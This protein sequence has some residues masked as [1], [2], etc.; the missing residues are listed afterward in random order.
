MNKNRNVA[1]E[2]LFYSSSALSNQVRFD[3]WRERKSKVFGIQRRNLK[4]I[5]NRQLDAVRVLEK[6]YTLQLKKIR[7]IADYWRY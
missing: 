3:N 5:E 2:V 7:N 1:C 4:V 6:K